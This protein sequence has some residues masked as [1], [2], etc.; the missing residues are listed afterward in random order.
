MTAERPLCVSLRERSG[1]RQAAE[2]ADM[3]SVVL[4]AS[5]PGRMSL[6]LIA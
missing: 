4:V 2:E 5:G 3:G 1:S 6:V